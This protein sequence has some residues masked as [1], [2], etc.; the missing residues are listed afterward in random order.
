MKRARRVQRVG[1]SLQNSHALRDELASNHMQRGHN[2]IA[3][4][5]RNNGDRRVGQAEEH[6]DRVEQRGERRLAQP[7]QRQRSQRN[8]KLTSRKIL[9]NVVGH[10]ERTLGAFL[11]FIHQNLNLRFTHA[12]QGKLG[13]NEKSVH[14]QKQNNQYQ[15]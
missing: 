7:A 12:H 2:E 5:H 1:F 4:A 9:V 10:F 3:N 11:A 15:T 13:D 8:T 6:E 14:Q